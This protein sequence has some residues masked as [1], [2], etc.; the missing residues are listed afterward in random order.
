M[1]LSIAEQTSFG[2]AYLISSVATVGLVTSY[3]AAI[4][5]KKAMSLWLFA[6]L[7]LQYAYLFILLHREDYSLLIGTLG[8]FLILSLVMLLTRKIDWYNASAEG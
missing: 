3:S 1:L 5:R 4:L 2:I 7:S 6:I 8:L